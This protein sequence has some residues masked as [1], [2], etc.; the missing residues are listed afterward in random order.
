MASKQL[1]LGLSPIGSGY[2]DRVMTGK[3]LTLG[4]NLTPVRDP[5]EVK[6]PVF[7]AWYL[8]SHGGRGNATHV[9]AGRHPLGEEL[10]DNFRLTCAKCSFRDDKDNGRCCWFPRHVHG[11]YTKPKWRA[12]LHYSG[13]IPA[14]IE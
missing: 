14:R 1:T 12:C 3:Q 2:K 8:F 13:P 9:I 7:P 10:H 6:D 4:L 5:P 11:V